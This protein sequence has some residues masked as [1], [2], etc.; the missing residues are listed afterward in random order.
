MKKRYW[1][2]IAIPVALI[3]AYGAGVRIAPLSN[4]V[5]VAPL[6]ARA[7]NYDVT[8]ERDRFGVPHISGPR[9]ADVAYGLGYAHSEDDFAT[10][11]D[12][13]MTT[14]GVAA[15]TKGSDAAVGDYLVHLL[16]VWETVDAGYET[17]IPVDVR[18]VMEAY[19]DGVNVYAATHMA[20]V[21]AGLLPLSG[22]DLAAGTVFRSPF[23]YGLD[24]ALKAVTEKKPVPDKSPPKGSNGIAVAPVRSTDGATRLLVNSHQPYKG[25]VAWYEAVLESGEGWHVAGGFFPGS[26]FMLHGHN[27]NLGWASTVNKPDLVDTYRLKTDKTKP[28]QYFFDGGWR[29]YEVKPASFRVKILGPLLWT[30]K[31]DVLYSVHGPVIETDHGSFAFSYAGQGEM[32]QSAQ[33][34]AMNKA[35]NREEWIAAMKRQA[36]PSINYI[37]A[38]A[39]GN[40]GYLHNGQFPV[41]RAKVNWL[42]IVPGDRSE[43]LWKERVPFERLPQIWNPRSGFVFNSNGNPLFASDPADNIKA[44]TLEPNLGLQSN[45]TNRSQRVLETYALDRSISADEFNSYKYDLT[46]SDKSL[47]AGLITEAL[48]YDATSNPDIAAAQMILKQWNRQTDLG[49][50]GAA[51]AILMGEPIGRASEMGE[52]LPPLRPAVDEAIK[53]LKQHFGRLDPTWGEVNRLR[54][55]K[56]DLPIAGGPDIYRAVYGTKEKDGRLA[57]AG[58]DTLIM[59]VEW[60]KAG[61]LSS[62]SIHQFGSATLDEASP[63]Y[64]DQVAMFA[65][66]KT[67]PVIFNRADLKGQ[68]ERS[69]RPG[70]K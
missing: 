17:K 10:I 22:K 55:G 61:K 51:L 8:V 66:G 64:A 63:H 19:A 21:P 49:N 56:L 9:D 60:D 42:D 70:R 28:G 27:A 30:V 4:S 67:K 23:F 40:I 33:Y 26:P 35:K 11:A 48:T 34:L 44:A 25:P 32:G 5:D 16:R 69:Y 46:Y 45:M 43:F 52:P 31:R 12:A 68:I 65:A 47:L 13:V 29:K 37:Y 41:R 15:E 6:I 59:F 62:R 58:G 18:A 50:R 39:R 20:Q 53:H 54:R 24:K 36:L 38:D 14:R 3:V 1:A 57:G 2:V 7:Q